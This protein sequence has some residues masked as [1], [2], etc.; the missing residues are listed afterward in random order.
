M[1]GRQTTSLCEGTSGCGCRAFSPP[2]SRLAFRGS[3][4]RDISR[5]KPRTLKH[6]TVRLIGRY[7][8]GWNDSTPYESGVCLERTVSLLSDGEELQLEKGEHT[9]EVRQ[10]CVEQ[11]QRTSLMILLA[12][13]QFIIIVP[14]STACEDRFP[15]LAFVSFAPRCTRLTSGHAQATSDV[16]TAEYGTSSR[17]R[18]RASVLWAATSSAT[19]SPSS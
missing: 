12:A 3:P 8:I 6:L 18:R 1:E 14:A 4:W 11:S 2:S 9:F 17:P 15:R 13:R 19:R 5:R 16:S 10:A 7:D